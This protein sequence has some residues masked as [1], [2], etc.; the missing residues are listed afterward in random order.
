MS[1]YLIHIL[2]MV[3]W[4]IFHK[5]ISQ[6]LKRGARIYTEPDLVITMPADV[7]VPISRQS[8]RYKFQYY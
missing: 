5:Q 3:L 1:G 7:L 4:L 8:A 6:P 2:G